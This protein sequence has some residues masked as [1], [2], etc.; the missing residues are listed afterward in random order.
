MDSMVKTFLSCCILLSASSLTLFG[1]VIQS[2]EGGVSPGTT[3]LTLTACNISAPISSLLAEGT[4]AIDSNSANCHKL[5]ANV[6]AQS[7]SKFMIVNGNATGGSVYTQTVTGVIPSAASTFSAYVTGLY[8]QSPAGIE[9]RIFDGAGTNDA[10]RLG[11]IQFNTSINPPTP[12][13]LWAKMSVAF[14]PTTSTIT[15][16]VFN[17]TTFADG[18]DFGIDTLDITPFIGGAII[19]PTPEP[20]ALL[21][22]GTMLLGIA[23]RRWKQ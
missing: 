4:Y 15:V 1:V 2:F 17:F 6:P 14:V 19:N 13:P 8:L 18:N 7:G 22:A 11:T 3:N 16:Q 21:L 5:W 9:L 10:N 20:G 23:A 12:N